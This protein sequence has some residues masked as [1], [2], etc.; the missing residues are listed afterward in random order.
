[1]TDKA[2]K[3]DENTMRKLSIT[4]VSMGNIIEWY[5]YGLFVIYAPIFSQLFFSA[6]SS[7]NDL[8]SIFSIF[9]IGFLCRP[10]GAL[11]FGYIGDKKGRAKTLRLSILMM[12]I[13]TFLIGCLPTFFSIGPF[14]MIFLLMV[15]IWQG[16]CIGGEYGGSFIYL[17]ESAPS[18]KRAFFT[19]FGSMGA[20]LGILLSIGI[21]S[22]MHLLFEEKSFLQW[23]WR[24]PYLLSAV[25]CLLL[26]LNRF[27]LE[28]TVPFE[29][30]ANQKSAVK[31]PIRTMFKTNKK[32]ILYLLGM[33]CM[34]STFYSFCI[35]YLP[36]V[37]DKVNHCSMSFILLFICGFLMMVIIFIPLGA[38]LCDGIGRRSML[39]FN[40]F[41]IGCLSLISFYLS[42]ES[43][44]GAMVG[45]F[46]LFAIASAFEQG[47][48]PV[49]M[50]EHLPITIRYTTLSFAYNLANGIF[51][52]TLPLVSQLLLEKWNG[53]GLSLYVTL[54]AVLT[55]M[56]VFYY[57][58]ESNLEKI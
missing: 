44:L 40:A 25:L 29:R 13:P 35:F 45:F 48:T 32:T 8:M 58:K 11:L 9:A 47:T 53:F 41:F 34:G 15:R 43:N 42:H 38:Y 24:L 27:H 12:A 5:D 6:T 33:G 30:M 54:S 1:M 2:F 37:L 26:Y 7:S 50:I 18:Q 52:G 4:T 31:N 3:M 17:T 23:G 49:S 22:L 21:A 20:N 56:V 16:I 51:G 28:E 57:V 10:L 46:S 19:S 55:G 14:A 39:L 36:Y